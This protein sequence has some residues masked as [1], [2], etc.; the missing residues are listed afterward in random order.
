M[1]TRIYVLPV[2]VVL[3][4]SCFS[5][6]TESH[7]PTIVANI[8]HTKRAIENHI[9]KHLSDT[10]HQAVFVSF[11]DFD[12]TILKGDCSEGLEEETL[13]YKGLVQVCIEKGYSQYYKNDEFKKIP[14]HLYSLR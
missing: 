5:C 11:W 10:S 2:I 14:G 3:I 6:K 8:L 1:N 13:I 4:V 9:E 12:G 7:A